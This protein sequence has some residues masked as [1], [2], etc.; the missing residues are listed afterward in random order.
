MLL[1]GLIAVNLAVIQSRRK[2]PDVERPFQVPGVPWGPLL[3]VAANLALLVNVET[4]SLLLGLG[5]SAAGVPFWVAWKRQAPLAERLGAEAPTAVAEYRSP[6]TGYRVLVAL[7]S[8]E[9]ADQLVR[10]ACTLAREEGEVM[11]MSALTVPEHTPLD[12]GRQYADEKRDALRRALAAAEE[13]DVPAS[14]IIR[15]A[16]RAPDAILNSIRQH[17]ADAVLMGWRGRPHHRADVVLGTTVDRVLREAECDVLVEAFRD[18]GGETRETNS[19]LVPT[20]AGPHSELAVAV[21]GALARRSG[22]RVRLVTVVDSDAPLAERKDR[23]RALEEE[24]EELTGVANRGGAPGR[25]GRGGGHHRGDG[26]PRPDRDGRHA[27]E[28]PPA[29]HPGGR[30]PNRWR[31]ERRAR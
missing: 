28:D 4:K 2:H 14:G 26:P 20:A 17:E 18:D 16:H 13:E 10:T 8:P 7:A 1:T 11:V 31:P 6:G 12:E 24:A 22:A 19:I 5:A 23:E 9:H 15:I 30:F 27:R 3:A 29:A 25:R 21:S